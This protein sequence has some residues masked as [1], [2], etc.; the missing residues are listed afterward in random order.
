MR[1]FL[2]L[3]I[4]TEDFLRIE[5]ITQIKFV[6]KTLNLTG[7]HCNSLETLVGHLEITMKSS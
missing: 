1:R 3:L 4:M 2:T 5:E 6:G 7:T